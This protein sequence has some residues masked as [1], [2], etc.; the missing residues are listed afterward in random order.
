M[1]EYPKALVRAGS[2]FE[3]EGRALDMRVVTDGD[4]EAAARKEGW[5]AA[6]EEPPATKR[7]K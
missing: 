2:E 7:K 6:H 5:H 1:H 4:E 3:W